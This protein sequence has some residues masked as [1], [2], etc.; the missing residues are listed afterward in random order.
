MEENAKIAANQIL[1]KSKNVLWFREVGIK[2]VGSVGGKNASLGELRNNLV[3]KGINVPDGFATTANAYFYFMEKSGLRKQMD[4][5]LKDVDIHNLKTLHE[6]G[7]K[8]RELI[9]AASLPDD[10]NQDILTAYQELSK[11]Y[12]VEKVDVAVRSS[13]T[14]EDLPGASFAGQQETYLNISG[15]KSV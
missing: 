4:E 13:A 1:P 5:I 10:L 3:A 15:E 6:K 8:V 11:L 12:G 14:A 7:Q 9:L 2:D